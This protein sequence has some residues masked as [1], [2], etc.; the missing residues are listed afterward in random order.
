VVY[1][2]QSKSYVKSYVM[3]GTAA[4]PKPPLT[5]DQLVDLVL[6]PGFKVAP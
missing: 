4:L 6:T 5:D 2:A 1:L 3:S